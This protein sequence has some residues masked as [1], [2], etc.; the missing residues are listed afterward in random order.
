MPAIISAVKAEATVGEINSV[1]R[2]EFGT[3]VAPSGV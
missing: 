1:L 3:W 2:E